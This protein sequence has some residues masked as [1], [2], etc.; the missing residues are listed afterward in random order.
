MANLDFEALM[1]W[2]LKTYPY[3]MLKWVQRTYWIT[4]DMEDEAAKKEEG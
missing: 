2:L 1:A 3:N 4:N